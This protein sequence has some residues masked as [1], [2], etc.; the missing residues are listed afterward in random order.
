MLESIK[1]IYHQV[2]EAFAEGGVRNIFRPRV[3]WNRLA[4]PVVM[5]LS[6]NLP[7]T[8][9][10][11]NTDFQFVEITMEDLQAGRCSFAI[12]SRGIKALRNLKRGWCGFAITK[13][14][15]V[16]GDVWCVKPGKDGKRISH[17]DLK[18]LGIICEEGDA[19]AFDMFIAPEFRGKNLAVPLQKSLQ[20]TLKMEGCQ[21]VYGNYWNDNLPAL[22]MHRMLKFKELPKRRISRFFFL[23]KSKDAGS[24]KL[25]YQKAQNSLI[26]QPN[27]K[28]RNSKWVF[29]TDRD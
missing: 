3:F 29:R 20:A 17:S 26:Q 6:T 2:I 28:S 18:M 7:L 23:V 27:G 19:Y 10:L 4:T 22:W 12:P 16:V 15:T 8:G 14:S 24:T 21:R 5:E 25:S 11:Q 1:L 9:H 13:D